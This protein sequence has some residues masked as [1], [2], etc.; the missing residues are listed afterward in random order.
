MHSCGVWRAPGPVS[1]S[2]LP[3]KENYIGWGS[4]E[5][6]IWHGHDC[7]VWLQSLRRWREMC[8]V[9]LYCTVF[10]DF[11]KHIYTHLNFFFYSET[12]TTVTSHPIAVGLK[13]FMFLL[14]FIAFPMLCFLYA[15]STVLVFVHNICNVYIVYH[16]MSS[17]CLRNVFAKNNKEQILFG[18]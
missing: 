11:I 14:Q 2:S 13:Q 18:F 6:S 5:N 1:K 15:F 17:L 8:S 7:G 12:F 3:G 16:S 4:Y 9:R 10:L